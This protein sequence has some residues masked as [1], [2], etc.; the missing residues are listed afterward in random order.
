MIIAQEKKEQNIVEYILYMWQIEDIIRASKLNLELIN[1]HIIQKYDQPQSVKEDILSWYENHIGMMENEQKQDKG[2]LIYMEN[3]VNDL[4]ELHLKLL[5]SKT[6]K[7]YQDLY[8]KALPVIS[9]LKTKSGG[10]Q[11][12]ELE[13]SLNGVYGFL[14]L[15]ISGQSI[16]KETSDAV[17]D[18]SNMLAYLAARHKKID[19]G[20]EEI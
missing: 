10:E 2:H 8:K 16:T 11:M 17:K 15:R 3:I 14:M 7:E 1:E 6:E 20:M 13:V 12:S 5:Q 19:Q 18:I 4:N 9:E